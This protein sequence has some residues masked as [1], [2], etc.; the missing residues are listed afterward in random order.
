MTSEVTAFRDISVSEHGIKLFNKW[1][2]DDVEVKDLALTVLYL[3]I[4]I[5]RITFKSLNIFSHHTLPVDTKSRGFGKP[6]VR[7][8]R[9]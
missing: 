8:L 9:D 7:S 1:S 5:S 3:H 4:L 2:F 6:S